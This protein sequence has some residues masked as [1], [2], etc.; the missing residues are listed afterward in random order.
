[1]VKSGSARPRPAAACVLPDCPC[2]CGAEPT[3]RLLKR[4]AWKAPAD[5]AE[6]NRR[7]ESVRLVPSNA[8]RN[9]PRDRRPRPPTRGG[10]AT[11]CPS[12]NC[13]GDGPSAPTVAS[14]HPTAAQP[15]PA[16]ADQQR[17][18]SSAP[19]GSAEPRPCGPRGTSSRARSG[20]S[21]RRSPDHGSECSHAGRLAASARRAQCRD[22]LRRAAAVA[23]QAQRIEGQRQIDRS[24]VTSPAAGPAPDPRR[25][26]VRGE[27]VARAHHGRGTAARHG[28]AG[29]GLPRRAGTPI[30]PTTETP[31]DARPAPPT[32]AAAPTVRTTATMTQPPDAGGGHRR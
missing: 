32:D 12:G 11:P 8:C 2:A 26:Q 30:A 5:E 18:P 13:D 24:I 31:A 3:V 25:A 4:G 27:R 29:P 9:R 22:V 1:M 7:A 28:R 20:N 15:A 6:A 16:H 21:P 19:S 14:R 10:A 23:I 17:S